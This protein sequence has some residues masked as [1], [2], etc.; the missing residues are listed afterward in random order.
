[1]NLQEIR[2]LIQLEPVELDT[3]KRR[4]NHCH[5]V[6]DL[7]RAARRLIP[8]P[9]FDY[10]DGAADEELTAAANVA[11]FRQWRFLPRVLADVSAVDTSSSV[12]GRPV[13]VPLALAPTGY[14]RMLH[15]D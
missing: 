9:V 12:L 11:A 10:V 15:Q 3:V 5:D 1:M 4:L 13:P 14:T 7:R 6:G 8:P 2:Q